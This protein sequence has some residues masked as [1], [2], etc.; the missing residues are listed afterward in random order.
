MAG[1]GVGQRRSI[2][3]MK[4]IDFLIIFID[5]LYKYKSATRVNFHRDLL[6]KQQI[7]LLWP[8]AV[9]DNEGAPAKG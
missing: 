4:F 3:I 8:Y 2:N 5:L 6:V 7:K 9:E 1:P